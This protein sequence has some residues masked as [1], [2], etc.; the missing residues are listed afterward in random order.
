MMEFW[1]NSKQLLF[2]VVTPPSLFFPISGVKIF[3]AGSIELGENGWR[4]KAVDHIS[5]TWFEH[6]QNNESIT[7]YDPQ[8][9]EDWSD[10]LENEQMTWDTSMIS[11]ADY[12]VLHLT[13]S[14]VSPISLLEV[15]LF[16]DSPK[17]F[18]SIDDSYVRSNIVKLYYSRFAQKN[19]YSSWVDS[20]D[21]ISMKH[22]T[23]K[24]F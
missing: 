4:N 2:T 12:I 14:S 3:L 20:I 22:L 9:N 15:G 10:D 8:R 21:Y 16:I 17:L 1:N 11:M 18:L 23:K 24:D 6:E 7:V 5:R 19:I 13:G